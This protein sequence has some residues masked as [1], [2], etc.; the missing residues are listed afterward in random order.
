MLEPEIAE[1]V[2]GRV[3]VRELFRVRRV[4]TV[5]GCHVT[6]GKVTRHA[7]VRVLRDGVVVAQDV[8]DSLK[9]FTEDVTEVGTNYECGI[10]LAKFGDLKVGDEFEA[11]QRRE[12]AR[13]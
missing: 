3:Q 10:G 2:I 8:V 6:E 1:E 4:G 9:R 5:A 7:H 12:I 13:T 11:F